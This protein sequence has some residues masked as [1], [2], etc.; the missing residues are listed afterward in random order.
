VERLDFLQPRRRKVALRGRPLVHPN[1]HKDLAKKRKYSRDVIEPG[2][3]GGL[4]M[5]LW[6]VSA[7]GDA[8]VGA[9]MVS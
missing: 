7:G 8:G 6:K 5:R 2:D 4:A 1:S 3:E 9:R